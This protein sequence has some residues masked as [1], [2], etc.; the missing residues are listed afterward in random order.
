MRRVLSMI[1]VLGA[2][3]L[4]VGG[5]GG[6]PCIS[7]CEQGQQEGCVSPSTDCATECDD[8]ERQLADG[9]ARATTAGC[10]A[11]FDTLVSCSDNLPVCGTGCGT[12]SSAL[13]SCIVAFCTDN[14]TSSACTTP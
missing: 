11:E 14:P 2:M 1:L 5:C 13:T 12:E 6:D 7:R 10:G 3:G 4:A 8:A 9:R